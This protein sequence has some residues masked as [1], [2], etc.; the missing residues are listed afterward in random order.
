MTSKEGR[1]GE[2]EVDREGMDGEE[3]GEKERGGQLKTARSIDI[4]FRFLLRERL[5]Q[6]IYLVYFHMKR[7]L[8]RSQRRSR[9]STPAALSLPLQSPPS[10]FI[11]DPHGFFTHDYD[12]FSPK[13]ISEFL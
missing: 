10:L 7:S 6:A 5:K 9:A 3:K 4:L 8:A 11:L 2:R 13:L 1:K 12:R